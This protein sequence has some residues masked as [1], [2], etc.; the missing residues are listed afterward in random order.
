[1]CVQAC[2]RLL[3]Y[4]NSEVPA[5]F[6]LALVH[7][8]CVYLSTYQRREG[9]SRGEGERAERTPN[10][11]QEPHFCPSLLFLRLPAHALRSPPFSS[12]RVAS[13]PSPS[14]LLYIPILCCWLAPSSPA[15]CTPRGIKNRRVRFFQPNRTLSLFSRD[16]HADSAPI[17]ADT[18][19]AIFRHVSRYLCWKIDLCHSL[20]RSSQ[21]NRKVS[22]LICMF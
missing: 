7:Q 21:R 10:L 15:R 11:R 5:I 13:T 12:P 9:C 3:N 16:F 6:R 2:C 14:L 18:Y 1:M 22:S 19:A 4:Y 8:R 17:D 20:L